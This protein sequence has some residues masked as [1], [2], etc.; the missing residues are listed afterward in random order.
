MKF[1]FRSYII[2][3]LVLVT[4]IYLYNTSI[5]FYIDDAGVYALMS[6][7]MVLR[8]DFLNLYL[9]NEDWLDKPHL[10]FWIGALFFWVFGISTFAYFLPIILALL[11]CLYYT[12]QFTRLYYSEETAWLSV[13][14]LATAQ[15]TF[16][17]TTEG[18]IEPY[19]MCFIMASLYHFSKAIDQKLIP[20]YILGSL[21][22]ALGIM[23]KGIL[24]IV[25]IFG[26]LGGHLLL[27]ERSLKPFFRWE[28]LLVA[29]SV[30][31]FLTPELYALYVQF[32]SHPEKLVFGRQEVSGIRWFLWDSQF[33]RF[34]NQG[35]IT[36]SNGD[37]FFFLH[38][39]LW[40][41]LPWSFLYYIAL[42]KVFFRKAIPEFY[43]LTGGLLTLVLFSASSF[44]LPHY[45]VIVFPLF[46][47]QVAD[48]LLNVRK[49]QGEQGIVQGLLTLQ[50]ILGF[51]LLL[52]LIILIREWTAL[53]LVFLMFSGMAWMLSR[54]HLIFYHKWLI[55]NGIG[56]LFINAFLS[57]YICALISSYRAD[58]G[59]ARFIN[60]NYPGKTV[61]II[62]Q[63]S[64]RFD[65]YSHNPIVKHPFISLEDY[66]KTYPNNQTP[67]LLSAALDEAFLELIGRDYEVVKTF[68]HYDNDNIKG[69]FLNPQTRKKSLKQY[70]LF[71]K[72]TD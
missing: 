39:L 35:P 47:I 66:Q 56:A 6:E 26:A 44:Q 45:I 30:F 53:V 3:L 13:F 38:T 67:L 31:L 27:R 17:S 5:E 24:I 42:I 23:T 61:M 12:F 28:W 33:S 41:F 37:Y 62:G 54:R 55:I 60:Q 1:D 43:T 9:D 25:P 65:F 36:R 70:H 52:G 63:A 64:Y 50:F 2:L 14:I 48:Y 40:A 46:A 8:Q 19:L 15:Y 58:I 22:T 4:A 51:V 18:R 59:V 21:F 68:D 20:Q 49:S 11:L 57:I 32:D 29:F 10:P 72:K 16:M 7:R 69:T 71:R 34:I